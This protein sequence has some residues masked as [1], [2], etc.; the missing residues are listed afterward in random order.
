MC[1]TVLSSVGGATLGFRRTDPPTP[2]DGAVEGCFHIPDQQAAPTSP[3]GPVLRRSGGPN[4]LRIGGAGPGGSIT[5]L[6]RRP[7]D[8]AMRQRCGARAN[9]SAIPTRP[10]PRPLQIGPARGPLAHPPVA[11]PLLPWVPTRPRT[12]PA[13]AGTRPRPTRRAEGLAFANCPLEH[14]QVT[15]YADD[16]GNPRPCREGSGGCRRDWPLLDLPV[17]SPPRWTDGPATPPR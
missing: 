6:P 8:V 3:S 1:S 11:H 13:A 2:A 7:V 15:S 12:T 14:L 9:H 4:A 16:S 10:M 5:F 17:R